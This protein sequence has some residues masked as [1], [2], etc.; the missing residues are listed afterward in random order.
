MVEESG[1]LDKIEDLQNH[2][3]EHVY[4]AALELIE[5]W[6]GGE[7]SNSVAQILFYN[8]GTFFFFKI[9][10]GNNNMNYKAEDVKIN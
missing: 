6:F 9:L 7:V 4:K 5:K 8:S 10:L 3:N 2:E 1:G